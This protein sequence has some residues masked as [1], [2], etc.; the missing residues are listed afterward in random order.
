[1]STRSKSDEAAVSTYTKQQFLDS[2]RYT[3]QQKDVLNALLQEDAAYTM[4]QVKKYMTEFSRK[5][6]N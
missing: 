5:V 2:S 1:M 3:A 6:A 4:E